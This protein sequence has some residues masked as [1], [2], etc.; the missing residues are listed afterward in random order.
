M[1]LRRK[2]IPE[3]CGILL[4]VTENFRVSDN[5][6][7]IPISYFARACGYEQVMD[8]IKRR[9]HTVT[10]W[11]L[12][13]KAACQSDKHFLSFSYTFVPLGFDFMADY[14]HFGQY[15]GQKCTSYMTDYETD[16]LFCLS[17]FSHKEAVV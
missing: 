4:T 13:F 12:S 10:T 16:F 8:R 3:C 9:C 7:M 6:I 5:G 11:F 1:I 14:R 2:T 15:L 17:F